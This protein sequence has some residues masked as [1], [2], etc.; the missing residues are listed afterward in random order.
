MVR[1]DLLDAV[2]NVM[3]RYRQHDLPFGGVQL[4]MIGDLQQLAPVVTAA[5][6]ALLRD[7]YATPY[8]F[9]STALQQ[10][11]YLT[12][13]LKKVFRQQDDRFIALLNQIRENKATDETLRQLNARFIPGFVPEQNSDYIQ[14]TTHNY[15][16]DSI[17]EDR[18]RAL[19]TPQKSYKA[20]VD[21]NFPASSYPADDVLLLKR[22]AQVM[23]IKNAPDHS[24]Y[25]GML[26]EV[27]D[28]F[29]DKIAVRSKDTGETIE[30]EP[31]EWT[32]AKYTLNDQ[33][34]EIEETVEGTFKQYP[35]RLAWAITIHKS[36]GLTFSHAIIDASRS[37]S[38][39]QTY[40]ALSRCKSLEGMV[41]SAPL[42]RSAII[43]DATVDAFSQQMQTPTPELLSQLERACIVQTIDE[44]FSFHSI[45]E[46]LRFFLRTLTEFFYHRS[47]KVVD[48]YRAAASNFAELHD[49]A[50][51]F[52]A[53]YT[54]ML[55]ELGDATAPALQDRIH[56]GAAYFLTKAQKLSF[57]TKMELAATDNRVA[58]KQ[59][60]ERLGELRQLVELK[61][62]LLTYEQT[63][64]FTVTDYMKRKARF[65][66]GQNEP[67]NASKRERKKKEKA[68]KEPK[69]PTREVSFN[70]FKAGKS[71]NEIAKER[72]LKPWTIFSHLLPYMINGQI[73]RRKFISEQHEKA[74][75]TY[76]NA[77]PDVTL[78]ADIRETM[79][80]QEYGYGEIRIAMAL[81]SR[82]D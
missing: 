73:D 28:T 17:N 16:A 40:V 56:K 64:T 31:M 20:E 36:Q 71:I 25:N 4:L 66:L 33:T 65:L 59:V 67:E 13:E 2:D 53:Q 52:H 47:P 18:L 63:A 29:G 77:H 22:G 58:K 24:F 68:Q 1:S 80:E 30:L 37:F 81:A 8:F 48:A 46:S 14:L 55:D 41:L 12:V 57:L 51:K 27:T 62:S 69:V 50:N 74:L 76:I 39:G 6:E 79:G 70:L 49:I 34:K 7:H 82:Q 44:L 61:V 60:D 75:L 5:D 35:L 43:S 3:R 9:S 32:N 45:E 23:F 15:Q 78:L 72:D 21:G 11:G 19:D 26:G 38:H 42:S 10:S 54:R